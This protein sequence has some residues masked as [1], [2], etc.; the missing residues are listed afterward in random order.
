LPLALFSSTRFV[1]LTLLTF[2]L[3]GA[4]GGVLVLIPYVL[5]DASGYS[6]T[7]AGAALLPLPVV[8]AV[9][10]PT[11]GRIAVKLGARLPLSLGPVIVAA[12]FLVALRIGSDV[13]YWSSTLPA[14]VLIAVGM[15]CAVAPLTTS[16]L[17]SVDAGHTGVASGFNSAVARGGGLFA[18]ALLGAVLAA[19]GQALE[20]MFHVAL[21]AGAATALAAGASAFFWVRE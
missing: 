5:I 13:P 6:A 10:S 20:G 2:L 1:G 7:A 4:L 14:M 16:V 9:L 11:M 15:A 18:T 3:Y 17:A 21:W 12:G 8:I 19:H